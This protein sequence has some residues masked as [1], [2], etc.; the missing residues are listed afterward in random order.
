MASGGTEFT[1]VTE[2]FLGAV[3]SSSL[4]EGGGN[5]VSMLKLEGVVLL[6]MAGMTMLSKHV[7]DRGE[8]LSLHQLEREELVSV[9]QLD[10]CESG[11]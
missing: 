10:L 4:S 6:C 5:F 9:Y 3:S 1:G 2:L 7:L 11:W 8:S